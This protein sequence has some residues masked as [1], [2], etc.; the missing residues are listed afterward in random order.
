[1]HGRYGRASIPRRSSSAIDAVAVRRLRQPDARRRTSCGA[2]HPGRAAAGRGPRG[3]RRRARPPRSREAAPSRRRRRPARPASSVVEALELGDA[4][5]GLEVG[6][7]V[8]EAEPVVVHEVHVRRPALVALAA[9]ALG[10]GRAAGDEHAALP[11]RHLLVRVEGEGG[12]IAAR[13]GAHAVGADRAERLR[14]R[15]RRCRGRARRRVASMRLHV[16]RE[17][18]DVHRQQA[19]GALGPHG[20]LDRLRDRRSSVAGSTSQKTGSA[21]SKSRQLD[22]RDE[23]ERRRQDL[24]ARP[25]PCSR[26]ARC[27]AAVPLETATAVGARRAAPRSRASKRGSIGPSESIPERSTSRTSSSSRS[28]STG[29]ASGI[30]SCAH[31]DCGSR[32]RRR[33]RLERVLERVDER[34]PGRL[35]DVLGDAERAPVSV[36]VGGVEEH[37]GHRRRCRGARRGS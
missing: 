31:A 29:R 19:R 1:M 12:G 3:H 30:R 26:T 34:L 9:R 32:L 5:R 11:R 7:P 16:G 28:P 23:A 20:G 21:P 18:E 33:T 15:P 8:V 37:A 14:R 24:V 6:E 4:E 36:A 35:D 25:P 2:P 10:G 17:A 22:G 27:R 13:A